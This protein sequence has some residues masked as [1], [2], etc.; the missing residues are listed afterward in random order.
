MSA[1][2]LI[3]SY[4]TVSSIDTLWMENDFND[5]VSLASLF[6]LVTY[7]DTKIR[8]ESAAEYYGCMVFIYISSFVV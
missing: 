2:T 5:F 4:I 7:W 1:F 6:T 3:I 8:R